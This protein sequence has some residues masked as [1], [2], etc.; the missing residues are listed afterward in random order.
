MKISTSTL[1]LGICISFK[2]ANAQLTWSPLNEPGSQGAIVATAISPFNAKKYFV[3]GDMLGLGISYNSGASWQSTFGFKS[4]EMADLSFHPTDSNI[5]WIGSMSG[6]YKSIDGGKNWIEKRKGMSPTSGSS[7]SV[8]IQKVLFDPNNNNKLLAVSGSH[9]GWTSPGSPEWGSIWESMDGG[10]N[11]SKKSG[12]GNGDGPGIIAA[13]F[14]GKNSQTVF[15][16]FSGKIYKS[17]DGAAL[18]NPAMSGIATNTVTWIVGHPT[19]A[20]ILYASTS[21]EKQVDVY[22]GGTIY[23]TI[24]GGSTWIEISNGLMKESNAQ[25]GLSSNYDCIGLSESSPNT[26]YVANN[27]WWPYGVFKTTNGGQD[28]TTVFDNA[29]R[30]VTPTA[31]P[32]GP[33]F[34]FLHVDPKNPNHVFASNT[35]YILE[36]K[37]SGDTWKDITSDQ[38]TNG[39]FIG[40]GYSGWVSSNAAFN[41]Y[42]KDHC[43]LQGLDAAKFW[44]SRDGLKNW[45]RTGNN[46]PDY[47]GGGDVTFCKIN[48]SVMYFTMGQFNEFNGVAKTTDG[49]INWTVFDYTKFPGASQWSGE[50]SGIYTNPNDCNKVWVV[51]Q[52]NLYYSPDGGANWSK[53]LNASGLGQICKSAA[54]APGTFYLPADAGV[55]KTTNGSTFDLMPGSPANATKATID[56]NDPTILYVVAWRKSNGGIWKFQNSTWTKIHTD[57]YIANIAVRPGDSKTLV[58]VTNDHPYHDIC[59]ASGIYVSTNQ[60]AN[61]K[62]E[63]TGLPVLRGDVVAFNLGKTDEVLF[64]SNGRGFFKASLNPILTGNSEE[65]N[66]LNSNKAYVY[67]SGNSLFY[68]INE[69]TET[70]SLRLIDLNGKLVYE[71]GPTSKSRAEIEIPVSNLNPGLY[72]VLAESATGNVDALRVLIK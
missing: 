42:V 54:T 8:P 55:Y 20:N 49:G 43:V 67:Q 18:W 24:N 12:I 32:A 22:K 35:A 58:A 33:G 5:V 19:D 38:T 36:T 50:P 47:S 29:K 4:Y 53:I 68:H 1:F 31:D 15:S 34:S 71:S 44:Q 64:G 9:R 61:W 30:Q 10:E 66:N 7:Y 48:T 25:Q 21:A 14:A 59:F 2:M 57:T 51:A 56:P 62:L 39:Q 13:T 6:P 46:I 28:W 63:N 26:L 23:K 40:R 60:G 16:V 3:S 72:V 17:I 11:W 52:N 70:T 65:V 41:P 45:K 27:S 37:N 69:G